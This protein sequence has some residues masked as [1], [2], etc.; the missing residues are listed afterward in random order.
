MPSRNAASLALFVLLGGA[1]GSLATA[2]PAKPAK[3]PVSEE[4]LLG[5][6]SHVSGGFFEEMAFERE[7]DT[8]RFDSWLHHRPEISDGRWRVEE[9]T[10]HIEHSTAQGPRFEFRLQRIRG[11]RLYLREPAGKGDAVYKRVKP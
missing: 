11:D 10:L 5:A 6:W 7:A 8:R 4:A 3:C 1:W 2:A 9:C